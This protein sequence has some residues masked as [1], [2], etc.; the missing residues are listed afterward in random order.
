VVDDEVLSKFV[1][2]YHTPEPADP[3]A[4]SVEQH[5][6]RE[7]GDSHGSQFPVPPPR[8][9]QRVVVVHVA[10]EPRPAL[11]ADPLPDPDPF[12]KLAENVAFKREAHVVHLNERSVQLAIGAVLT[13]GDDAERA[14]RVALALRE[15]VGEVAPGIAVGVAVAGVQAIVEHG[16]G[17]PIQVQIP[18]EVAEHI[19]RLARRSMEGPVLVAG[20][21]AERLS[22]TWRFGEATFVEPPDDDL[23]RVD[24]DLTR[25]A[26]LVG[27]ASES[28]R[29][30]RHVPGGRLIL[31]GREIELKTLRDNFSEAIRTRE[32]RA[33]VV[34]GQPGL[35][36][37]ALV[38]RFVSSLPRTG[39]WVLRG[40]GRWSR[41]NV[42]LG[43]FLE[44]LG[45]FFHSDPGGDPDQ[46]VGKL[47]EL[48]V[49]VPLRPRRRSGPDRGQARGA[50]RARG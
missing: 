11:E 13:T 30:V 43:V 5:A 40:A 24:P 39:C 35:G 16:A 10:L 17:G 20:D 45:R 19:D 41:R 38:E 4:A 31:Y 48:G 6:T 49:H 34:I 23:I 50:G 32:S 12:L 28:E 26:P 3:G 1:A 22:R 9:S 33:V 2:K 46:I 29:H 7:L 44:L 8:E 36:K 21:L 37:R 47:E 14:L 27:L 18:I 15:E 25:A 42:P